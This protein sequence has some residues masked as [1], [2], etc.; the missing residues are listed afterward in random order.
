M[1]ITRRQMGQGLLGAAA[2]GIAMPSIGARA[3]ATT[4]RWG[5]LL[6]NS[7][8]QVQMAERIAKE[9]KEKTSGRIDIQ[10][11]PNGQLGSGKDIIESVSSGALQMTT[12]GAG[13]LAAFL[14][15]LSVIESPYLWRDAA[16]MGKINKAPLLAK[17]NDDLVAKRNMRM[18]AV[19]YYGKR[20]LTTGS[21]NIQSPAD[22]AGFKL[23]VPPVDVFLAMAEAW[24]AKATPI[25]FPELYLALS[26]GAVDGQENPL[27]T[28]QSGKFFEVQKYL[29][30]TEHI[31]TPRMIVVNEAFW[32]SLPAADRT[33]LEAAFSAGVDWQDKELLA[34]EASAVATL[35]AQ[36]MT[37]IE[38]KLDEWRK[39]VL[40]VV[41][42]KFEERWGKGTIDSLAAL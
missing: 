36:G 17:L 40:A 2:F 21:K 11:F 32:K 16:H 18:M 26:S 29:V 3:Q 8:P 19:T 31:I 14:P 39:P 38:P 10:I 12:D 6:A 7:H 4:I 28:I 35:K 33:L 5:E 9:V 23:R 37:V 22:M 27:P 42:K 1:S 24:G 13:A 25:A 41:P 30:L 34:Q 15:Q 20:H